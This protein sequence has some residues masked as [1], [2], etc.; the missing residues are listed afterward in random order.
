MADGKEASYT[1]LAGPL[2]GYGVS[3]AHMLTA[4]LIS[5]TPQQMLLAARNFCATQQ[6]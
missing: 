4:V 6:K 5:S 3:S 1:D 2:C